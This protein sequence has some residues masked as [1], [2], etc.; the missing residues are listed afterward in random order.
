MALNLT[1]QVRAI[2]E[3]TKAVAGGD[4]T[5]KITV[6][7]RGEI[8]DLKETVNGMTESLSVFADEMTRLTREIGSDGCF[9]GRARVNDLGGIWRDITYNL[10]ALSDNVGRT[11]QATCPLRR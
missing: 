3:V 2:T 5:K 7:A 9:G 11:M 1:D 6:D 10:N 8:L 4:L